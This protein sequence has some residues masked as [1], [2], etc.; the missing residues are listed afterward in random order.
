MP[1]DDDDLLDTPSLSRDFGKSKEAQRLQ[2]LKDKL[3]KQ[4][5][6]IPTERSSADLKELKLSVL[7]QGIEGKKDDQTKKQE[8]SSSFGTKT[9]EQEISAQ[10]LGADTRMTT[11]KLVQ[12]GVQKKKADDELHKQE[13]SAE[14]A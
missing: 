13:I 2:G 14:D 1:Y 4:G 10:K 9:R 5:K 3:H 6:K 8:K 11:D 12:Q 7:K